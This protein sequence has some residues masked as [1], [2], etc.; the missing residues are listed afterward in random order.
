M[1][2]LNRHKTTIRL[3]DG[4]K[5]AAK[6]ETTLPEKTIDGIIAGFDTTDLDLDAA[7]A[8]VTKAAEEAAARRGSVV[9]DEYRYRY[10]ADQNCGDAI[11]K[12][13][14]AEV[15]TGNGVD[16]DRAREI[17]ALNGIEDRFDGWVAKGL[18]PG[19]V[20]MNLGNVLRGMGR[21]AEVEV[22]FA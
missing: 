9:P 10:G 6:V 22:R 19:M 7:I 14:T 20:R 8:A 15:T 1:L 4:R 17:A 18:N 12:R 3:M 2:R 11:A 16:L 5:V 21:K 13:L